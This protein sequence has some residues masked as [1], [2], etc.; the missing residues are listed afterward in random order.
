MLASNPGAVGF[1]IR[2]LTDS[3]LLSGYV[4]EQNAFLGWLNNPNKKTIE[5]KD[6]RGLSLAAKSVVPTFNQREVV[7]PK[8]CI[9]AIDMADQA[10]RASVQMSPRQEPAVIYTARFAIQAQLHPTGDMPLHHIFNVMGETAFFPTSNAEFHP[11]IPTRQF[12]E[13]RSAVLVV[14]REK[15]EF[16]HATG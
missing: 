9:V 1:H 13:P 3:F 14:N 7:L 8:E 15:V 12:P 2:T 10:G 5:L 16:Y 11:L 4:E 6:V